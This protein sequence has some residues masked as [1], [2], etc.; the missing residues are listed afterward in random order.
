VHTQGA[1]EVVAAL[2]AH[3]VEPP[4]VPGP[5]GQGRPTRVSGASGQGR[6]TRA[7]R[8]RD[9]RPSRACLPAPRRRRARRA[10]CPPS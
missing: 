1:G 2:R 4:D 10:T 9:A 5:G 3:T 8:R 6:P 7:G